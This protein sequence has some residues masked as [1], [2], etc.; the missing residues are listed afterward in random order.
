[1]SNYRLIPTSF[2]SAEVALSRTGEVDIKGG[3]KVGAP[4]VSPLFKNNICHGLFRVPYAALTKTFALIEA[5][6]KRLE[7]TSLLTSFFLLVIQRSA[8][9]DTNSLL[10]VVY[11]CINKVNADYYCSVRMHLLTF[12]KLSPDYVDVEMGIGE[13]LLIKAISE[14]T[15]RSL[16]VVKTDLKKEGDLGLVAMAST[17]RCP[18]RRH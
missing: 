5:T 4:C 6:T 13:S 9:G 8:K 17:K 1:L 15:G 18:L 14:S 10:Q 11:L 2:A 7:K 12:P 3:W 16:A